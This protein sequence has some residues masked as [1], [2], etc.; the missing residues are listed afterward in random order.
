MADLY[1]FRHHLF[2]LAVDYD[3]QGSMMMRTRGAGD[4]NFGGEGEE[5]D[6]FDAAFVAGAQD[7]AQIIGAC[8]MPTRAW[9][10]AGTRP[11]AVAVHDDGDM[12]RFGARLLAERRFF[13][14]GG[15]GR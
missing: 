7:A 11:A 4:A 13:R 12:A 6:E 3:F 8:V 14:A 15:C 2:Q 1:P 5:G 10:T 9:Q